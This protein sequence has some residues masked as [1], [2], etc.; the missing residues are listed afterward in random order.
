MPKNTVLL[1]HPN[2]WGLQS[3]LVEKTAEEVLKKKKLNS[4]ELSVIFVGKK[5]AKDLNLK[6]REKSYVP[7]VLGFP[8]SRE[9]D[10][11]G[12]I[13]LGDIVICTQKLKYETGFQKKS[14]SVILKEWIEHGVDNLLM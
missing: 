6:Y 11:D 12:M 8:M 2:N 13:R 9:P 3:R 7:Q 4:I 14:I 10:S 5:R 1:K